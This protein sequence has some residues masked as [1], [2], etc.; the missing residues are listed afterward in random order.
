MDFKQTLAVSTAT[1]TV[2]DPG[3]GEPCQTDGT[4]VTIT[5]HGVDSDQHRKAWRAMLDRRANAK[6]KKVR[7]ADWEAE[8]ARLLAQI[9]ES[10]EGVVWD[11]KPL[12]CTEADAAM[13]YTRVP[14]LRE[15]LDEFLNERGNFLGGGA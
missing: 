12:P 5:V 10:W 6:T 13:L 11:G 2:R 7:S 9:T 8:T 15:Q 4:P 14:W 3:T 1:M